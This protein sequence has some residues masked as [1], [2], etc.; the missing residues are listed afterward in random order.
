MTE[1]THLEFTVT[2]EAL[3]VMHPAGTFKA[4]VQTAFPHLIELDSMDPPLRRRV[5]FSAPTRA[6]VER[7]AQAAL[8][9]H[10]ERITRPSHPI[11]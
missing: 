5:Y 11:A 6:A 8:D 10:R 1:P 9:V 4:K 7:A 3:S 2:L